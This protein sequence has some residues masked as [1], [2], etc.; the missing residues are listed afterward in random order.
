MIWNKFCIKVS[1]NL[2]YIHGSLKNSTGTLICMFMMDK[3]WVSDSVKTS[4]HLLLVL[5]KCLWSVFWPSPEAPLKCAMGIHYF[6]GCSAICSHVN[7]IL[8]VKWA[9]SLRPPAVD[10]FPISHTAR[11]CWKCLAYCYSPRVLFPKSY[12][13][14]IKRYYFTGCWSKKE[15]LSF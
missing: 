14:S 5:C 6:V 12:S 15:I 9:A 2:Y 10:S 8:C 1:L 4:Y 11:V 13:G 3:L 7:V